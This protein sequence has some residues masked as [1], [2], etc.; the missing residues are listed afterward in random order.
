MITRYHAGWQGH[1]FPALPEDG[2]GGTAAIAFPGGSGRPVPC[3][4]GQRAGKGGKHR[5]RI[6][7]P[8]G[9]RT[10]A[11]MP[12]TTCAAPADARMFPLSMSTV[13]ARSP[14]GTFS[15]AWKIR[16]GTWARH[17]GSLRFHRVCARPLMSPR[18]LLL[19]CRLLSVAGPQPD[20]GRSKGVF[21]WYQPGERLKHEAEHRPLCRWF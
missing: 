6:A 10:T 4:C 18:G 16:P 3:P 7:T 17:P 13:R 19:I 20:A 9:S 8:G 21:P 2:H 14:C 11:A 1:P 15:P 12:V 5:P